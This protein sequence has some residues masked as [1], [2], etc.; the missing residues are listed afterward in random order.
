MYALALL[1]NH[2]AGDAVACVAGRIGFLIV[3]FG[4]DYKRGASVTEE[5]MAVAAEVDIFVLALEMRFAIGGYGKVWTVSGV[6]AF[7][8]L[9]AMLLVVGIEMASCGFEVGGVALRVLMEVDGMFAGRQVLEVDLHFYS[10][11]GFLNRSGAHNLSS[12]V[13]ELNH[14]LG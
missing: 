8:I 6:V 11:S 7:R 10:R 5:R 4:V 9:Q 1:R 13:L 12:S 3:G 2:A 14:G